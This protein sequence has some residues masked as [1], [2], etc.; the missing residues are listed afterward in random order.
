MKYKIPCVLLLLSLL[1]YYLLSPSPPLSPEQLTSHLQDKVVLICGASSGIG[2]ELAQQLAVLGAKVVIVARSQDKLDAV[3]EDA[4][5]LGADGENIKTIS[6]DFS[7]VKGSGAVVDQTIAWFGKL[8]Y[9]VSNHAAIVNGPFLGVKYQ[10]DPDYIEKIFRVNLF[11]HIEL[12][13]RALPH[14]EASKGHIYITSSMASE[15][16]MFQVGMYSSTKHALNGFF[17]SLQQELI[18]R[19]SPTSLTV[20]VLGL[21]NTK[22]VSHMVAKEPAESVAKEPG[23]TDKEAGTS[24]TTEIPGSGSVEECARQ[25]MECYITRPNT[26]TFPK[27]V[28]NMNRI[29]WYFIPSYHDIMIS[30]TKT[31]GSVGTGYQ[32]YLDTLPGLREKA[33]KLNYQQ[34]YGGDGQ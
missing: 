30:A 21:I 28:T 16:P 34:G 8:D 17:Y 7:N 5:K 31:P 27:F 12:T 6:F 23:Q 14:L 29:M 9:L 32:E 22:E 20:G 33:K 24:E 2:A 4:V 19:E 1:L 18:A 15:S 13:V 11:S 26:M 3:K 25:I 10:Q